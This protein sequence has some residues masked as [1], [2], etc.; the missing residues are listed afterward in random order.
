MILKALVDYYNRNIDKLPTIGR[1]LKQIGFI[2]TIDKE[3]NFLH[4]EDA[5]DGDS[6]PEHRVCAEVPRTSGIAANL[7]YDKAEYVIGYSGKEGAGDRVIKMYEA[8]KAKIDALH[9]KLPDNEDI[10]SVYKFYQNGQKENL[11]KVASDPCWPQIEQNLDKRYSIFSFRVVGD[12]EIIAEKDEIINAYLEDSVDGDYGLD[13]ITGFRDKQV[14]ITGATPI[15][16]SQAKAKIVSFQ[17]NQGLD[18]YGKAQCA[19]APIGEK[20]EFA[21][22][23]ALMHMAAKGSRNKFSIGDRTYIFWGGESSA[24]RKAEETVYSLFNFEEMENND[25]GDTDHILN[26]FKAVYTGNLKLGDSEDDIFHVLGLAPNIG[27]VAVCHW[28]EIPLKDFCKCIADHIENVRIVGRSPMK[29]HD[30]GLYNILKAVKRQNDLPS[31]LADALAVSIFRGGKYPDNLLTAAIGKAKAVAHENEGKAEISQTLAGVMKAYLNRLSSP[32]IKRIETMLDKTNDT[33]AY[34]C[35]RLFATLVKVQEEANNISSIKERYMS[36]A[37]STPT[38]IFPLLLKLNVHHME[39]LKTDG[40]KVNIEKL[41]QEIISKLPANDGFPDRLD[42]REQ[43]CF[44]VGYYQQRQ[45]FFL[46]KSADGDTTEE[47]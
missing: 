36:S 24:S 3:G 20:S 7:L 9:S 17:V 35:G 4:I 21:F 33:P 34:L 45:D 19:N 37:S 1:Q 10:A 31:N 38:T 25:D 11:E 23:T 12:Y 8:F 18:S 30:A 6:A 15:A 26:A 39:N 29:S 28:S 42:L 41:M 40:R 44:F 5:R 2:I 22:R 27:R 32:Q 43:A 47:N 46:T 16:G 13:L 14:R